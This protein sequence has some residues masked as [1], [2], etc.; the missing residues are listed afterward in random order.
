MVFLDSHLILTSRVQ[1]LS[2]NDKILDESTVSI[3]DGRQ[4]IVIKSCLQDALTFSLI[5]IYCY[6]TYYQL[7]PRLQQE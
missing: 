5:L 4:N 1:K 2:Y 6:T 7:L 3:I